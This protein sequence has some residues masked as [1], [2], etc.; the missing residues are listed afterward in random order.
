MPNNVSSTTKRVI[1]DYNSMNSREFSSKYQVSKST[2]AKRVKKY[3]DPYM[4]S[5]L[6][7]YGKKLQAKEKAAQYQEQ[8]D[9]IKAQKQ[10]DKQAREEY[11]KTPEGK[12]ELADKR[13]KTIAA[14][15]AVA[16]TALAVYGAY[17][18]SEAV[19]NKAYSKTLEIGSKAS[20]EYMKK[21]NRLNMYD[22][23]T[24]E[25]LN[26]S[27]SLS[28]KLTKSDLRYAKES[29]KNFPTAV[30]TLLNK[31]PKL[32]DAQLL[33]MGIDLANYPEAKEIYKVKK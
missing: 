30:K 12:K 8:A 3:G 2:Y 15:A 21:F 16:G 24:M 5:P 18:V 13:A 6:A 17:K 26:R 29:S 33:N 25:G 20:R 19:K 1:K 7:K 23:Q 32:S 22:L 10:A 31:N 28:D 11:Y 4:N 14:G 9:K 27:N